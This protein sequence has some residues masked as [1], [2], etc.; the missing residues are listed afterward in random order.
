MQLLMEEFTP[1]AHL[2]GYDV[3]RRSLYRLRHPCPILRPIFMGR[4][5]ASCAI[6]AFFAFP[7]RFN[8]SQSFSVWSA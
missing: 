3:Y 7:D 6:Y 1:A 8:C 5:S 4:I 2:D